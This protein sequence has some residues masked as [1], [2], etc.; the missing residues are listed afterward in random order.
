MY[1]KCL[2]T[3]YVTDRN[4]SF[5]MADFFLNP[6]QEASAHNHDYYEFFIVLQGEFTEDFGKGRTKVTRRQGHILRP[7]DVHCLKNDSDRP[8]LLRNIAVRRDTFEAIL[9]E[10]GFFSG[11]DM[12]VSDPC[13]YF[14][15]DESAFHVYCSRTAMVD[16][17]LPHPRTYGFLMRSIC[18]DALISAGMPERSDFVPGWLSRL[19]SQMRQPENFTL[20]ILRMR[21]LSGRSQAYI[22]RMFR[23]YY[24][25]TPTDYINDLRLSHAASL[26]QTTGLT[27]LE[28]A[29]ICGFENL[30]WFNRLFK[31]RYQLT[32][33]E[34]RSR[35]TFFF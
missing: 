18:G 2:W 8:A 34:Y 3:N 28:I 19:Y 6:G 30:S 14:S 17:F 10:T 31:Q 4:Q 29:G 32:P 12:P 33:S 13:G 24:G 15:L 21:E 11:D 5:Y 35:K 25:Q 1:R 27:V 9:A 23:K 20:G 16:R 7:E 26:L 22:N